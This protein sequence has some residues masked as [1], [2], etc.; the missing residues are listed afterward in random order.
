VHD[1]SQGNDR[2][3]LAEVIGA[4]ARFT[5]EGLGLNVYVP[6]CNMSKHRINRVFRCGCGQPLQSV[7]PEDPQL[8]APEGRAR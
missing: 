5:V 3:S 7:A 4:H 1:R 6:A 2:H 8:C